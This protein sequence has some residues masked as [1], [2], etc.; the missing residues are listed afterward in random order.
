MTVS[1]PWDMDKV[2]VSHQRDV[3]GGGRSTHMQAGLTDGAT[4]V[5]GSGKR[6]HSTGT[7]NHQ[8]SSL[9]SNDKPSTE[10]DKLL[11]YQEL[12]KNTLSNAVL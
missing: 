2:Y 11:T 9:E 10:T 4:A 5:Q 6:P 3:S 12:D 1:S 8:I 7:H